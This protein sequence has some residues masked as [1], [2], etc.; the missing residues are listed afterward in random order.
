[1]ATTHDLKIWPEYFKQVLDGTKTYEIRKNDRDY[2]VGDT[3]LLREYDYRKG[4]FAGD[5]LPIRALVLS[6]ED[7]PDVVI[8]GLFA[9]GEG[10]VVMS[11]KKV[12]W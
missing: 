11:I 1:M 4:E 2:K 10:Y 7:L 3:L 5:V 9:G 6:V 12:E 8:P